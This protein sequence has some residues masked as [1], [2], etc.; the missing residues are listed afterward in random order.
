M[1][2]LSHAY[3][4]IQASN[5]KRHELTEDIL[6]Q[7]IVG[8]PIEKKESGKR[9]IEVCGSTTDMDDRDGGHNRATL[10]GSLSLSTYVLM[11]TR[12]P[13]AH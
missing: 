10:V 3:E 11:R 4:R 1:S 13:G 9:L 5:G 2:R 12:A 8:R 7:T 6:I